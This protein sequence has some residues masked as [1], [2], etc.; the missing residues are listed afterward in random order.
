MSTIIMIPKIIHQV[1]WE[2]EKGRTLNRI[3]DFRESVRRTK[4]WCGGNNLDYKLW[5]LEECNQLIDKYPEYKT[6]WNEF[7]KQI[8][9]ADFIRYLILFDEGGIYLDCD[10][11]P[12]RS[13]DTLWEKDIFFVRWFSDT[14]NTPY[15][16]ILGSIATHPVYKD[17]LLH[18]QESYYEKCEMEIYKTWTAR[19]VFQTTGHFMVK[20]VLKNYKEI[21]LLPIVSV[22]N[23]TKN[24]WDFPDTYDAIFYDHSSSTWYS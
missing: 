15:Q 20:R 4:E 13:M 11:Y 22:M 6:I 2:F 17:I 5:G 3:S 10:I 1:F 12:I 19:F 21:K 18:C 9:K 7:P 24:I 16:A 14:K 8:M 23:N